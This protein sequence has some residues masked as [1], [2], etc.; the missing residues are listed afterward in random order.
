MQG[1]PLSLSGVRKIMERMDWGEV[2][3]FVSFGQ[4]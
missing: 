2:E 1:I 4:V 3:E